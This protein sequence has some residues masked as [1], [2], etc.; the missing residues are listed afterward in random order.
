MSTLE[1][2]LAGVLLASRLGA[3]QSRAVTRRL[4]WDGLPPAT[5]AAAGAAEGYTRERVRQLE[6]RVRH[7][8][9]GRQLPYTEAALDLIE[10]S[11]PSARGTVAGGLA[12]A[13]I[14]ARPFDPAGVLAAAGLMGLDTGVLVRGGLVLQRRDASIGTAAVGVA[15]RLVT[16]N[17]A[18][19]VDEIAQVLHVRSAVVRRLLHA[20]E[21][22]RWLD[23]E[24]VVLPVG[25]SRAVTGLRKML[26]VARTLTFP[27]LEDGLLRPGCG[28]SLPRPTLRALCEWLD[29]IDVDGKRV[30]AS[31]SI[32]ADAV[33]SPLER[34]L[35]RIFQ[36][37]GPVLGFTRAVT[38]AEADGIS[39]ASAAIYL[40]KTPVLQTVR[41]GVYALRGCEG[42]PMAV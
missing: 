16:R 35:F 20:S 38:L 25:R 11:A 29:W 7:H 34:K 5:L 8:V 27:Q 37:D 18:A 19:R 31:V 2:E 24:W 21:E 36:S 14:A 10:S 9:A 33:L 39:A 23:D 32:D 17:G 3:K 41:R 40:G 4:G 1:Q 28:V 22:V 26:A 12:E 6:Q 30:T 15:R 13:G 42:A